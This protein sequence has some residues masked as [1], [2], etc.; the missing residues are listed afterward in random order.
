MKK[1]R[2]QI[3]LIL[4]SFYQVLIVITPLITSP[5]ISRVLGAE[6]LG[7]YSYSYSISNYFSILAMLGTITYG[8]KVI[9]KCRDD[10][11]ERSKIFFEIITLQIL[12]ACIGSI[13]YTVIV[14][15]SGQKHTEIF[16]IQVMMIVA[17]AFN[18]GWFFFGMEEFRITVAI[19][20]IIK[21]LQIICIFLF[22]KIKSDLWKYVF[23]MA[24]GEL[25]SQLSLF[26]IIRK[27][28][29]VVKLTLK[30]I[31]R[32][33][34]PNLLLFIPGIAFAI[35][36]DLDKTMIGLFSS[37]SNTGF[38][39]NA[40]KLI[41]IPTGI[42]TGLGVVLLPYV[43]NSIAVNKEKDTSSFIKKSI[44][45]MMF[46][47]VALSVG[48]ISISREFVPIFFGKGYEPCIELIKIMAFTMIFKAIADAIRT[49]YL[50]PNDREKDYSTAVL[51]GATVNCILNL[52]M[53]KNYGAKGAAFATFISEALVFIIYNVI[54]WKDTRLMIDLIKCCIFSIP[55]FFMY[56]SVRSI[57]KIFSAGIT[58]LIIEII[59]G[60]TV[61][62]VVGLSCLFIVN[63]KE[64]L[65]TMRTI[66][67]RRK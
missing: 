46:L 56:I 52:I 2:L 19:N 27:Y 1:S 62:V 14:V 26:L 43:T 53:I 21:V 10:K 8:S 57:A 9:A 36:Q 15:T 50:I 7:I 59:V 37:Y 6:G 23:I 39:Y 38:Y 16:L 58:Q 25:V 61:Y 31:L 41:K 44:Y 54:I 66:L 40:E 18:V 48:I 30:G 51:V 24:S 29:C 35:N 12:L 65:D 17:C 47:T 3:N 5:Y 11:C 42:I 63:K 22:V 20:V 28:V 49:Q 33:I 45:P 64:T 34:K 4:Q 67:K 32:H 13:I 60:G 55:A